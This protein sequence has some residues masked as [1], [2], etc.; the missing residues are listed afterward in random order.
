MCSWNAGRWRLRASGPV[1]A[2]TG[3]TPGGGTAECE[4]TSADPDVILPADTLGATYLGG[5]PL[6]VL[7]R[8]G[9]AT[10]VRGGAVAALSAALS[11]D[12]APWCPTIF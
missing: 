12:P 9:L 1:L 2:G 11:W 7:A 8:A 4:R 5:T 10:E 3:T 6:G